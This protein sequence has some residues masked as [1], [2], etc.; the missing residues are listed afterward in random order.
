MTSEA[1]VFGPLPSKRFYLTT[2]IYY[3][4]G[5][6]HIGHIFTTTLV[7]TIA[8]WFKIRGFDTIYTSG[9]DEHGLKVETTAK[10]KGFVPQ[11]WCDQTTTVFLTAFEKF[12]LHF[13]DFVRTTSERH[14]KTSSEFWVILQEKGFIYKGSYQGWYSKTEECFVPE[15]Q[16]KEI[17]VGGAKKHINS[18]DGAELFWQSEENY[19]FKLSAFQDIL[20]EWL[21]KN[22]N[23]ITPSV[24]YN[25]VVQMIKGGLNDISVFSTKCQVGNTCSW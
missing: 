18:E 21:E 12:N 13:D 10:S 11:D 4:N 16:V 22:P 5:E 3:V 1:S 23:V 15:N 25:Q 20:L 17:E 24:Y 9:V 7:E 8:S 6:P 14:I 2:P 19:M